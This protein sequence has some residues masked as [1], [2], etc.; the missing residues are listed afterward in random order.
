M[1]YDLNRIN[2]L[3]DEL[4]EALPAMV[5]AN[6]DQGDFWPAFADQSDVIHDNA[7]AFQEL[8][9]QRISAMLVANGFP[10]QAE[11]IDSE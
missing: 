3:L 8:V 6:P 9:R 11:A 1:T 2:E 7:G 4:E 5:A 10:E